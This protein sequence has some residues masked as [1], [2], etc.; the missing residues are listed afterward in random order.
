MPSK[1]SS[2]HVGWEDLA[3]SRQDLES[4]SMTKKIRPNKVWVLYGGNGSEREVSLKTGSGVI[5]ALQKK[6]FAVEG[7]DVK[8]QTLDSLPWAQAPDL[9]FLGLHGH[10]GE[11]G[12]VQGY[13]E[14][15]GIPYVGSGVLSSALSFHKGFTR[16]ALAQVGVPTP[17]GYEFHGEEHFLEA[18]RSG[19]LGDSFFSK[20]WFIK[21]AQEGSTV[22]I[23]RYRASEIEFQHQKNRF[24][25][26]FLSSLKYC[27]DVVVEEWIEGPEVTVSVLEGRALPSVEIRPKSKFYDYQSKYTAGASEY[28]CPA[29]LADDVLDRLSSLAVRTFHALRCQDYGR[30]DFIV[31][32]DGPVVLEMNTL[33]GLTPTSLFPKAAAAAGMPYDEMIEELV[34]LSFKRQN[35]S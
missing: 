27:E 8:P 19:R 18:E 21:P 26:L 13:L 31:G 35:R 7:F 14:T 23:E 12:V 28:F 10:F 5:A 9:I 15:R 11:D 22:G 6:G 34:C 2:R 20:N 32:K 3:F 33:P 30:V 17:Y 4:S 29:P 16:N 1:Y 25:E 24:L